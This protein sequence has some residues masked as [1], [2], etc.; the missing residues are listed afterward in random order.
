MYKIDDTK[1]RKFVEMAGN[2]AVYEVTAT[3]VIDGDPVDNVGEVK[4]PV[5]VE[6]LTELDTEKLNE[7]LANLQRQIITDEMNNL[8]RNI[9]SEKEK[10]QKAKKKLDQLKAMGLSLKDIKEMLQ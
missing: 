2:W 9:V 5:N 4:V 6:A 7:L 1:S 8:R 10:K 3:R